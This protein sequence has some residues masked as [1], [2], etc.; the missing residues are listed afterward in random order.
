MV[1]ATDGLDVDHRSLIL[2]A[3]S[4]ARA[5]FGGIRYQDCQDMAWDD[6][7]AMVKELSKKQEGGGQ[8]AGDNS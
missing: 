6:Y 2:E 4:I 7:Q 5:T 1:P 3:I 8:N